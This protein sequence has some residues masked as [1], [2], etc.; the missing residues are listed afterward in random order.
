MWKRQGKTTAKISHV[1]NSE[2][3]NTSIR[4]F[5]I[6]FKNGHGVNEHKQE[7]MLVKTAAFEMTKLEIKALFTNVTQFT[8]VTGS[9]LG[10]KRARHTL[11]STRA[12]H[13]HQAPDMRLFI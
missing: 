5:Q 8:F 11:Q 6:K 1:V 9:F 7:D 10:H 4:K 3:I 13:N 12:T 2:A